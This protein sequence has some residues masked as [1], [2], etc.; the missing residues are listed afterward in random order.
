MTIP[1]ATDTRSQGTFA[2]GVATRTV[3]VPDGTPMAGYAGRRGSTTGVHDPTSVRALVIDGVGIVAVDVCALH[4]DTC[5]ALAI[6]SGLDAVVVAATHTHSGPSVGLGRVGDHAEAVHTAVVAAA[7][8]ALADAAATATPCDAA[9]TSARGSGVAKDRRHL[10]RA[11][12]PPATALTF[13]EASGGVKAMLASY[14]CHPVVLDASNT[15]VTADW[16]HP[17]RERLE[18][19]LDAPVVFLTGAAGDVNDGH[20]ADASF[21]AQTDGGRTFERAAELGRRV[22]DALL[23]AAR[24][25]VAGPGPARFTTAP[26]TLHHEPADAAAVRA[27]AD[28]WRDQ[29]AG[30]DAG[31]QA[32]LRIW[33]DWAD[34]WR[35]GDGTQPWHGRVG[36]LALGD[37]SVVTLPG[38]PFLAVADTIADR[39]DAPVLVAAYCDGVPGYLPTADAYPEGGYEVDDAHMYYAMPGP[40]QRGSAEEVI[41]AAVSLFAG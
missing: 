33:I 26:L 37:V 3:E 36:R 30:A 21:K 10:G 14:P 34:A 25:P 29:L 32:V 1:E 23:A 40:F 20:A 39:V 24:Q 6:A 17:M 13:T 4:E 22:A 19:A 27:R 2:V 16:V 9:W 18:Q 35:P 5:T 38:E 31:V 12:D 8:G 41:D 7:L 28:A 11:I 15:L